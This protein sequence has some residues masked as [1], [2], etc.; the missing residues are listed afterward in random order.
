MV[1]PAA[2]PLVLSQ[3]PHALGSKKTVGNSQGVGTAYKLQDHY[4][5]ALSI[6]CTKQNN[7][8]VLNSLSTSVVS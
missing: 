4:T 5:T 8:D 7:Y 1:V 6:M 2:D 3:L